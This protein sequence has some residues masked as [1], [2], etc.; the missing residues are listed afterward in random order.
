MPTRSISTTRTSCQRPPRRE[1][2]PVD[3]AAADSAA[4][5][6][7][8]RGRYQRGLLKLIK[9]DASGVEDMR[10]A[11]AAVEAAQTNPAS[12]TFWWVALGFFDALFAKAIADAPLIARLSNRVEQQL[13]RL[14]EGSATVAERLMREALLP[15]RVRAR[16]RSTC[17]TCKRCSGSPAPC[18]PRSS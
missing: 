4:Y 9:K 14:M 18:P 11:V 8:Q 12:R 1:K 15:L 10:A 13:K 6:R 5:Y 3:L 7:D 17:A 2:P 16:P